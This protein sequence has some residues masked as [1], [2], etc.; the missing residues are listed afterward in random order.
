MVEYAEVD[1]SEQ[2]DNSW[3]KDTAIAIKLRG[4]RYSVKIKS[5][6]KNDLKQKFVK[7]VSK[8]LDRKNNRRVVV[9]IYC[10]LLYHLLKLS[11]GLSQRIKLCNDV[12]PSWAVNNYLLAIFK[13]HNE[14]H[15]IDNLKISFKKKGDEKSKAHYVAKNVSRGREPA[16]II[17][18]KPQIDRLKYLIKKLM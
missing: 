11:N 3:T 16:N 4:T 13:E 18:K 15:I 9:I 10:Y 17:L 2:I 14:K 7:K 1:L 8:N 12:S 6:D 5:K